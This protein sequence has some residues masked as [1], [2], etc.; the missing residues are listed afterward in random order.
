M[1]K[2]NGYDEKINQRNVHLIDQYAFTHFD[3]LKQMVGTPYWAADDIIL[4]DGNV[5]KVT[6]AMFDT[7]ITEVAKVFAKVAEDLSRH[8]GSSP[9]V[10]SVFR[11]PLQRSSNSLA[12]VHLNRRNVPK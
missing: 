4:A 2:E 3:D 5:M 6:E 1:M 11:K 8:S 7:G 9:L 10:C 12:D